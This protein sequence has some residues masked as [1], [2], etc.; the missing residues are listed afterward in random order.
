M[1]GNP[2]SADLR[3][4]PTFEKARELTRGWLRPGTGQVTVLGQLAADP[5]GRRAVAAASL[6][7]TLEGELKRDGTSL[8]RI[9]LVDLETGDL[10]V[11]T[12]GPNSDSAPAWS[13][14]G[15]A[16]A[17]LSDREQAHIDRLRIF[18]VDGRAD[19]GTTAVD[20]FIESFQ[21]SPDGRSILL[22]VAGYGSDVAG[23]QGAFAL[24]LDSAKAERPSW[25]PS[26]EGVVEET[27]WRSLWLYDVVTDTAHQV[28]P[29]GINV[30]QGEWC[31]VDQVVALCSDQP[32]ET[33]W[34]SADLRLIDLA[35]GIVRELFRPEDQL[36]WLASSPSGETVAVAEAV[37][38]DRGIVMGELR[39]IDVKSGAVDRPATLDADVVQLT[40]RDDE[41]LLFLGARGPE[42]IAGL[43]DRR[44]G[45]SREL[46]RGKERT[47]SGEI[48]PQ[49]APLGRNP[50]DILFTWESFFEPPVLVAV[51]NGVERKIRRFGTPETGAFV[52]PLGSARDFAWTAPDGLEM[53]GWLITPPGPG[54]HPVIVQIHGGPVYGV[55]PVYLGRSTFA[56]L[57]LDAGYALFQP[58]VRGSGGR[59]LAFARHVFGDMGGV[60]TQDHLSGLDALVEAGIADPD[61]IGLTGVSYGGYMTCWLITQDSRFAAAVPVAPTA[62]WVSDHMTSNVPDFCEMFLGDH[63]S[64]PTGKYFTRSPIHHVAQVKTPTMNIAGALDKITHPAQA[65]EFH[66]ALRGV[67]GESVLVTY[68]QEGHGVKSMPAVFDYT[69]RMLEWFSAHMPAE[70]KGTK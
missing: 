21:W 47:I 67:G 27:P 25:E 33:W 36:G 14:D 4:H 9:A 65:L 57:A 64:D 26:V 24:D 15:R 11:L 58:N 34:Y 70:R 48:F 13:P 19:R 17:Y 39:L 61:R 6:C 22:G 46:W 59:G 2:R 54:P 44:T 49:A 1:T 51:E 55:P 66:N 38:S 31:G 10:E 35:D 52:K 63:V 18:D 53:H 20:G 16:I 62:D 5:D 60:D 8:T 37:C 7:E 32:E 12:Q 69:T 29:G 50:G 3:N 41:H 42:T 40:W 30:W 45:A 56:Q 23:V 68:P 43:F 28:S